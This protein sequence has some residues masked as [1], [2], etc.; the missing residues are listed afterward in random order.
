MAVRRFCSLDPTSPEK[1][2][3]MSSRSSGTPQDAAVALAVSDLPQPGTPVMSTPFGAGR[4]YSSALLSQAPSRRLSQRLRLLSPPIWS[5]S[6]WLSTN[7]SRPALRTVCRFSSSTIAT[8]PFDRRAS[9][10]IAPGERVLGL[11]HRQTECGLHELLELLL[12]R[13]DGDPAIGVA[14]DHRVEQG[15]EL[16]PAGQG[17]VEERRHLVDLGRDDA[18]RGGDHQRLRLL[19]AAEVGRGLADLADDRGVARPVLGAEERVEVAEEEDRIILHTQGVI[20]G[21]HRVG[22]VRDRRALGVDETDGCRPGPQR[23]RLAER[24]GHPRH[25]LLQAHLLARLHVEQRE[26]RLERLVEGL[27]ERHRGVSVGVGVGRA[28]SSMSIVQAPRSASDSISKTTQE[29][30]AQETRCSQSPDSM[31]GVSLSKAV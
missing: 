12:V 25:R 1:T 16:G 28:S 30:V 27:V 31:I 3:P 21:A 17:E 4:P 9:S 20:E 8:S 11:E 23:A 2:F 26:S 15:P 24:A 22:G 6:T 19:G 13:L 10:T 14:L 5:R 29:S 7:S 18:H